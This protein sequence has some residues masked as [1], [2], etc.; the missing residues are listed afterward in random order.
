MS[1]YSQSCPD[2][3]IRLGHKFI[4]E[5]SWTYEILSAGVDV[6]CAFHTCTEPARNM[7]IAPQT[8][9]DKRDAKR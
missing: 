5:R 2:H 3:N 4:Q 1:L 7:D 6:Q 8:E 9:D